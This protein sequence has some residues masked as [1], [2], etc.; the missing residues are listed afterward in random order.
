MKTIN[1][2]FLF[3]LGILLCTTSCSN[4]DDSDT[5]S[6][7]P[8]VVAFESLSTNLS[9]IITTEDITL[10]YSESATQS[11]SI[12]ISISSTN[13]IYGTDF[14]T[15]PPAD[16][17]VITLDIVSGT[18]GGNLVFNKLNNNLDET[19]EITFTITSIN[20]ENS[21]IQG[22]TTFTISNSASLGRALAPN[23]GG[24]MKEIKFT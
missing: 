7:Q 4:E 3:S 5:T 23:L 18:L 10:V 11:G 1:L 22:N 20:Y 17:N 16:G 15:S 6:A 21:Q 8:F 12:S 2:L 19:T 9:N 13:A 14:S 24:P